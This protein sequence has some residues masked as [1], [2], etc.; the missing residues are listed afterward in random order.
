MFSTNMTWWVY[1]CEFL[2][3]MDIGGSQFL[4]RDE[5]IERDK[6][7]FWTENES[8]DIW[9]KKTSLYFQILKNQHV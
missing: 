1:K 7:T 8:T 9:N 3:K 6:A 2:D 4:I 5:L